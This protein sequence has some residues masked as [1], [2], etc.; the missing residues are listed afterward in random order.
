MSSL[1][2]HLL[3]QLESFLRT[4]EFSERDCQII[5]EAASE[6]W[7]LHIRKEDCHMLG[8]SRMCGIPDLPLGMKWPQSHR[9]PLDFVMQVRLDEVSG[10]L[11][12]GMPGLGMLY[13]FVEDDELARN[14]KHKLIWVE[15]VS[16]IEVSKNLAQPE[17][18][19]GSLSEGTPIPHKI[20]IVH[21]VDVPIWCLSNLDC[22]ER[23]DSTDLKAKFE[24]L[25]KGTTDQEGTVGKLFGHQPRSNNGALQCIALLSL[26]SSEFKPL[27]A[28][29]HDVWGRLEAAREAYADSPEQIEKEMNEWCQLLQVDSNF[30]VG[31]NIWDAGSYQVMARCSDIAKRDFSKSHAMLETC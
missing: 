23:E 4:C 14:V 26:S 30:E 10:T 15:D 24:S 18:Y 19:P 3:D 21:G 28:V 2:T 16:E 6:C 8:G 17:T 20:E 31:Y 29:D 27:S 5:R 7:Y 25:L 12:F 22:N 11:P 9:G 13:F 1:P